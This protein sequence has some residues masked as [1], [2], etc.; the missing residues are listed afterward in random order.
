MIY[1]FYFDTDDNP[2]KCDNLVNFK[3]WNLQWKSFQYLENMY[4][5]YQYVLILMFMNTNHQCLYAFFV[6]NQDLSDY[7]SIWILTEISFSIFS[8]EV[9][10]DPIMLWVPDWLFTVVWLQTSES[11]SYWIVSVIENGV[12]TEVEHWKY[13]SRGWKHHHQNC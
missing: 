7:W 10:P 9:L 12:C 8:L 2:E 3:I 5:V 1:W 13:V 6:C 11:A 4:Q